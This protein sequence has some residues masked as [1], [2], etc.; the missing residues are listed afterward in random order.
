MAKIKYVGLKESR[1]DTVAGT[2]KV[3]FGKGDVQEVPDIAVPRLL[4]HPD[5]WQLVTEEPAAPPP[6]PPPP[7]APAPAPAAPVAP[8]TPPAPAAPSA[9]TSSDA[10]ANQGGEQQSGTEGGTQGNSQAPGAP[11]DAGG[12]QDQGGKPEFVMATPAGPLV[13]DELDRD[14]LVALAKEAK[15]EHHV[16]LGEKKLRALLVAKYPVKA[17]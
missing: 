7:P 17:K 4:R 11:Q 9:S 1:A 3:W 5:I 8:T 13:L 15:V 10:G 14:T 2:G 16:N 6:P 12:Q